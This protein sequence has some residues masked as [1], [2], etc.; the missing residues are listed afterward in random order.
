MKD[1]KTLTC[2]VEVKGLANFDLVY[3]YHHLK[4]GSECTGE[5]TTDDEYAI[6]FKNFRL[7]IAS[8]PSI[9]QSFIDK[10]ETVKCNIVYMEKVKFLPPT[11]IKVELILNK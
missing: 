2:E 5:L 3:I 4:I 8:M 7:G 1:S 11:F 10:N 9:A 6:S